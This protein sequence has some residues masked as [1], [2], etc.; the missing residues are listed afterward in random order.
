MGIDSAENGFRYLESF[1]NLEKKTSLFEREYRLDRVKFLFEKFG[2]PHRGINL[3]HVAGSKGKG[4][5]AAFAASILSCAGFRTG[6]YAS[7]HLLTYR[8]R[9]TL[10]GEFFPD[11]A[12]AENIEKIRDFLEKTEIPFDSPPTTF[13]L[14][15]LLAFITFRSER[16]SWAVIE[17]GIGGRL[18][19]TNIITPFC[20]VITPIEFE[21]QDILGMTIE[22]IASEKG[23]IIKNGIPSVSADQ[24]EAV[25]DVLK[26]KAESVSSDFTCLKDCAL[27]KDISLSEKG[28]SFRLE[29]NDFSGGKDSPLP[30]KTGYSLVTSLPGSFQAENASLAVIAVRKALEKCAL[31]PGDSEFAESVLNGVAGASIPGRIEYFPPSFAGPEASGE[32]PAVIIDSSHTPVSV[33]KLVDTINAFDRKGKKVLLFGSVEGKDYKKMID[34]L[35]TGGFSEIIVS[36]PGS[37][38]KSNPE[39]IYNYLKP[40]AK[41]IQAVSLE[42]EPAKAFSKALKNAGTDG[43]VVVT[44]SFYMAGEIIKNLKGGYCGI[45]AQ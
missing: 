36:T 12:Y 9:I 13:E 4:S 20:S 11:E 30:A 22:E 14:L 32:R 38:K 1:T 45:S 24:R 16:C 29:I 33:Q 25:L 2:S 8:E 39:M 27:I 34:V 19:A 5:T 21:H 26:K 7:P 17:T 41:Q 10:S 35:L 42:L 15:T 43:L 44:G 3:I 31:F 6:V 23:G 28:T 37:F 40:A 18:D